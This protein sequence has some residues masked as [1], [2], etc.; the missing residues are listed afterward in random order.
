LYYV[1]FFHETSC[2][3]KRIRLLVVDDDDSVQYGYERYFT[4]NDFDISCVKSLSAAKAAVSNSNFDVV[5]LDLRLPD[6]NSIGWIPEFKLSNPGTQIIVITGN[7]EISVAVQAIKSGADNFLTKPVDM[8]GLKVIIDKCLEKESLRKRDL[9]HQRIAKKNALYFGNSSLTVK[10]L[11]YARIAASSSNVVLLLGETGTGK[12]LLARWIHD[13]SD[14]S[15]Q[16][17]VEVN[18]SSLKGELLRSE[19]FG[20]SRGAFTSAVKDKEGLLEV[21]D[22]GTL[23]L[24]EIGE[25][26]I[27]VQAL[28][29][30]TIEEKS[31]RRLGENAVRESDFRLL[32]ATNRNL[33]D[34]SAVQFRR[35]LYYRICVFPITLSGL[36]DKLEELPALCEYMLGDMGYQYLPLDN[37]ILQALM[38]YSWPGNARE[39]RN[40][41]ERAL[42]LAQNN[43]LNIN[44]FPGLSSEISACNMADK[45]R[46]LYDIEIEHIRLVIDEYKGNMYKA[47]EALGLSVSSLYRRLGKKSN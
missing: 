27:D 28:L 24:D 6:G 45:S 19:L 18:C 13:H 34:N 11:E 33:L 5:L 8:A 44:H 26:D 32:C 43:K 15:G 14:R 41:L 30:K 2:I 46:K 25:M 40:M 4:H 21:A 47:G 38:N 9:A 23:F 22:G 37:L 12:G 39:L 35:D 10:T 3:M 7:S 1:N 16:P 20:H 36:R 17:F 42:M 29:L 31:F